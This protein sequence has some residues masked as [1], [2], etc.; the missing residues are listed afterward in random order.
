MFMIKTKISLQHFDKCT[1]LFLLCLGAYRFGFLYQKVPDNSR[2]RFTGT[3]LSEP[4][5]KGDLRFVKLNS[6]VVAYFPLY[7]EVNYGDHVVVEGTLNEGILVNPKIIKHRVSGNILFSLRRKI[8]QFYAKALPADYASLVSGMTLGSKQYLSPEL[9]SK[10][11]KTGTTHVVVASGMN[12]VLVAGA[13]FAL[14]L[15]F[16]SR[17]RA[18]FVAIVFSWIYTL[19]AGFEAPL[20]RASIM[21]T[22]STIALIG[23]RVY[24]AARALILTG[25][26]MII[27][28]PYWAFDIG[29]QLSFVS[30]LSLICLGK[31][32]DKLF[33][34]VPSL[35]RESFSTSLAAQMGV[36]PLIYIY[37]GTINL[38]SPFINALI[39]WC[40][41]AITIAGMVAGLL[42]LIHPLFGNMVLFLITP[43]IWWFLEVI[44][45]FGS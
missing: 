13:V 36:G 11:K 18:A 6:D 16:V 8:V 4:Q 24:S 27:V 21:M 35:F 22:I 32:I 31:R 1:L 26:I 9:V 15:K 2:I 34:K 30:T 14:S 37:F 44:S 29:F 3:I 19:I 20:V 39:L 25:L 7:P 45:F 38:I 17:R 5:I 41:P 10:L 40:V 23:G 28:K 43:F 42:S 33:S 12:I